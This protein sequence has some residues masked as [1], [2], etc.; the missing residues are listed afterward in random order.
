MVLCMMMS[1]RLWCPS[2]EPLLSRC[3]RA[4]TR[5]SRSALELFVL[6]IIPPLQTWLPLLTKLNPLMS[7][8]LRKV[9]LLGLLT[10]IPCSTRCMTTLKRPLPTGMFRRWHILRTLP[11]THLRIVAGFPTVRTLSGAM[12][13]LDSGAFVSM[14]LRLRMSTRCDSDMRH[15]PLLFAPEATTTLSPFCPI[16]FTAILLLTLE[17]MVGPDGPCVLK[18]LAMCG[19]LLATLFVLFMV[20]GTP[21]SAVL[22][23]SVRLLLMMTRF[24]MGRPHALTITLL[25]L[26]TLYTG[27]RV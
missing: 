19:R 11:M 23:D 2:D 8:R 22:A 27:M 13:L 26:M 3:W 17:M 5:F 25:V 14:V 1:P 12:I 15:S 16:P 4:T 24:F 10:S 9:A 20:C 18:S 21:M 7:L 6:I